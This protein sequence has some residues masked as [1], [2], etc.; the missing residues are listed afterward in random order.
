MTIIANKLVFFLKGGNNMGLLTLRKDF[1]PLS[2]FS[3]D[4]DQIFNEAF[5]GLSRFNECSSPDGECSVVWSPSVEAYEDEN[6]YVIRASLPGI[7]KEDINIEVVDNR[8]TI[9]GERKYHNE[10]KEENL[11]R[12]EFTYGKFHRSFSLGKL[13]DEENIKAEYKDGILNLELPLKQEEKPQTRK[14]AIQ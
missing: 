13:V 5:H 11:Y 3:R 10:T 14:I 4:L 8:L 6:K 9:T 7:N 12:N 1:S 2:M